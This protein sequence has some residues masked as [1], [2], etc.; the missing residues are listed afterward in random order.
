MRELKIPATINTPSADFD[1][2]TQTLTIAGRCIPENPAVFFDG[3]NLWV[4]EV[5]PGLSGK[6]LLDF[7]FEYINS[8][9]SKQ[10]LSLLRFIEPL[11][12]HSRQ[13]KLDWYHEEDDEAIQELG[14]DLKGSL[15]FEVELHSV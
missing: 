7:R 11:H 5:F 13:I 4:E 8:G 2:Q 9:S 15:T 1:A 3:L 14:E 6:I 10:V 12:D